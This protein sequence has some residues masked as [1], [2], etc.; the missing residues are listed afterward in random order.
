MV[1]DALK[2]PK[3]KVEADQMW[4][5]VLSAEARRP[6]ATASTLVNQMWEW[7]VLKDVKNVAQDT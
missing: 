2:E 1:V 4:H 6:C 7:M 5:V 3:S